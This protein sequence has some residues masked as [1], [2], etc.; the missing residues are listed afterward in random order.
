[1]AHTLLTPPDASDALNPLTLMAFVGGTAMLFA[2]CFGYAANV[3]V[4][5]RGPAAVPLLN[6]YL[7]SAG[8]ADD[9]DYRFKGQA[10]PYR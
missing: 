8:G 5:L 1:M 7:A 3:S 10:T 2:F 4:G 9:A 6:R